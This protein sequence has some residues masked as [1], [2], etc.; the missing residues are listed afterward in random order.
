MSLLYLRKYLPLY[1]HT[2]RVTVTHTFPAS[3]LL[4]INRVMHHT[5]HRPWV[6]WHRV[7]LNPDI[8]LS[9]IL[10]IS[11]ISL[12]KNST[13]FNW[14][15]VINYQFFKYTPTYK[16]IHKI[17]YITGTT[18]NCPTTRHYILCVIIQETKLLTSLNIFILILVTECNKQ[19]V[20]SHNPGNPSPLPQIF[21][22]LRPP[23]GGVLVVLLSINLI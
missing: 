9:N 5:T 22:L 10:L 12:K 2:P 21:L 7:F 8:K 4:T 11:S 6:I 15:L 23:P 17:K 13:R 16:N 1:C 3:K 14:L 19:H 20:S 18:W